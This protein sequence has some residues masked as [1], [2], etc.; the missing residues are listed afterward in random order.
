M[1]SLHHLLDNITR[2]HKT[3]DYIDPGSSSN[4]KLFLS[5]PPGNSREALSYLQN[6]YNEASLCP[7]FT[8]ESPLL[9]PEPGTDSNH[10]L[11]VLSL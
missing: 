4:R 2:F 7:S 1:D 6:T 10:I 8:W 9:I 3:S 5:D 11:G